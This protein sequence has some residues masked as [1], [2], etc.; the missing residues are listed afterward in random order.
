MTYTIMD[1]APYGRGS[2]REE[3]GEYTLNGILLRLLRAQRRMGRYVSGIR[4]PNGTHLRAIEVWSC[5]KT[6]TVMCLVVVN[7][8]GGHTWVPA[9]WLED[10]DA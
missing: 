4:A 10:T 7:S 8:T 1:T 9:T 2:L 3:C 6:W 5:D